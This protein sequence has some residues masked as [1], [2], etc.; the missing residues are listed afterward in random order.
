MGS[1]AVPSCINCGVTLAD[2][3]VRCACGQ[4]AIARV[5]N[6]KPSKVVVLQGQAPLLPE[7]CCC[8]LAPK[9]I[10]I[11]QPVYISPKKPFNVAVPWCLPC[12]KRRRRTTIRLI[13]LMLGLAAVGVGAQ[14]IF[15]LHPMVALG[16]FFGGLILGG[17]LAVLLRRASDRPG[18]TTGCQ[19]ARSL[20]GDGVE[21][22]GELGGRISFS[23][24]EFARR[25]IA[26]NPGSEGKSPKRDA[27]GDQAQG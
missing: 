14:V 8:C 3:D 9:A 18:H 10:E 25:W 24:H 11:Q 4:P 17:V 6:P 12:A 13:G 26:L 19:A 21:Q 27:P 5:P 20:P 22:D 2:G 15:R 16:G 7:V 1:A 23:N